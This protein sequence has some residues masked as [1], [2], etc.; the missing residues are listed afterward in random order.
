M[1]V[2]GGATRCSLSIYRIL[3]RAERTVVG[4][5]DHTPDPFL[6]QTGYDADAELPDEFD[7]DFEFG[8][9]D[10]ELAIEEERARER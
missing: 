9:G 6:A 5:S 4:M 7:D 10:D 1:L 8:D 2:H 3:E